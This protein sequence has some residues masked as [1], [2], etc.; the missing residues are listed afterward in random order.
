VNYA[1][2][3]LGSATALLRGDVEYSTILVSDAGVDAETVVR[4]G[5]AGAG[6][7]TFP[8]TEP[9]DSVSDVDVILTAAAVAFRAGE[10]QLYDQLVK[11]AAEFPE[12]VEATI[13]LVAS[14]IASAA[15]GYG[16]EP[17]TLGEKLCVTAVLHADRVS[18]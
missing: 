10:F 4:T 1:P 7:L 3:I 13:K 15:I 8:E 12:A 17:V 14:H 9:D 2:L 6:T 5:T 16:M 18:E 11:A